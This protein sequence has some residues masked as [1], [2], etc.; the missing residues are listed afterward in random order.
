MMTTMS[1]RMLNGLTEEEEAHPL[2]K[3]RRDSQK[4]LFGKK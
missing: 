2:V 4:L 1:N 3:A